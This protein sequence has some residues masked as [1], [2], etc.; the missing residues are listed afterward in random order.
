MPEYLS[1]HWHVLTLFI[2]GI[3]A[4]CA[5]SF[6]RCSSLFSNSETRSFKACST[7]SQICHNE[8]TSLC[9]HLEDTSVRSSQHGS[10]VKSCV[11]KSAFNFFKVVMSRHVVNIVILVIWTCFTWFRSIT[12]PLQ[13]LPC[14][15][16][17][18]SINF[19]KP[20]YY[21]YYIYWGDQKVPFDLESRNP[22]NMFQL[23]LLPLKVEG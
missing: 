11:Q 10:V 15:S 20:D 3:V 14:H 23:H 21:F 8:T 9:L 13:T 19:F 2:Q 5:C 7:I 18:R 12:K 4:D 17:I 1:V 16:V 22:Y 6:S